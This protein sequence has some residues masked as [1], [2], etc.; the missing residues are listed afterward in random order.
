MGF[1]SERG[2]GFGEPDGT[3]PSRIPT[4]TFPREVWTTYL[5]N[6][7]TLFSKICDYATRQAT[8]ELTELWLVESERG[9]QQCHCLGF[10]QT[11]INNYAKIIC[12]GFEF[13]NY[14]LEIIINYRST[15][16]TCGKEIELEGVQFPSEMTLI[17]SVGTVNRQSSPIPR[18]FVTLY[19]RTT[20]IR[21]LSDKRDKHDEY[22][23]LWN[24]WRQDHYT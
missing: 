22:D 21:M 2:L 5:D 23:P 11:P 20:K 4:S 3:P 1:W 17:K 9:I 24:K 15:F 14:W 13:Y 18:K 6:R 10:L 7:R 8:T 12:W 16:V 19:H